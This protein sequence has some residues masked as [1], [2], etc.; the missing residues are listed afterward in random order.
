MRREMMVIVG[1]L[2]PLC[3]AAQPAREGALAA[4]EAAFGV[5]FV[6]EAGVGA[7]LEG[8]GRSQALAA[9][10]GAKSLPAALEALLEGTDLTA[11]S[12]GKYVIIKQKRR[13]TLSGYVLDAASGETLIGAGVMAD[14]S[15]VVTNSY[16]FFSLTLP[17]G[18]REIRVSY[19][20]Y[21]PVTVPLDLTADRTLN[22]SL[23][24]SGEIRAATVIS[25]KERMPI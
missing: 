24:A 1:F 18:R 15:G 9:A 5:H 22:F 10:A 12:S 2:L 4:V 21:A 25:E 3:L 17:E 8:R 16:G 7:Q 13:Y 20:G 6:Y 11:E 23:E 14:G 19:V